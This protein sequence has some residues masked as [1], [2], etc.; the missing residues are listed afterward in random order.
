MIKDKHIMINLAVFTF[1]IIGT[2]ILHKPLESRLGETLASIIIVISIIG[3]L[4]YFVPKMNRLYRKK[5]KQSN[6]DFGNLI[7]ENL[8]YTVHG[9]K[10]RKIGR[11]KIIKEG[12]MHSFEGGELNPIHHPKT[13][14]DTPSSF[15]TDRNFYNPI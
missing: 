8:I 10:Y 7:K 15:S 2:L 3:V 12:A 11:K 4:M 14:G 6:E 1:L 13:V 9:K 5:N